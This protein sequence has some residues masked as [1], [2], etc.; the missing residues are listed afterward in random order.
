MYKCR[1]K[2]HQNLSL[3]NYLLTSFQFWRIFHFVIHNLFKK[4]QRI[5]VTRQENGYRES[6]LEGRW[7]LYNAEAPGKNPQDLSFGEIAW[8]CTSSIFCHPSDSW[9]E[10][11]YWMIQIFRFDSVA[12]LPLQFICIVSNPNNSDIQRTKSALSVFSH[13]IPFDVI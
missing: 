13:L 2:C 8:Q 4:I 11:I 7:N 6:I 10:V 1:L 5:I 3:N 9:S 12:E